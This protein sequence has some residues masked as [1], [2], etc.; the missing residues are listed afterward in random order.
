MHDGS[1]KTL[2]DVVSYYNRGGTPNDYLDEEIYPLSLT[3]E[4]QADLVTFLKDGLGSS[5]Y[6]A[7]TAP[8]L[9]E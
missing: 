5:K 4:E 6:P 1:E 2:V 7:E 9:P 8:K 3:K